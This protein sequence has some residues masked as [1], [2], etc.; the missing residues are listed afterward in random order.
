[1]DA[2]TVGLD[3]AK[4]VFHVHVVDGSGKVLHSKKL[5]RSH[6]EPF[7]ARLRRAVVGIEACGTA[8]HWARTLTALGHEVRLIPAAY[9]KPFVRRNKNDAR[10]AEGSVRRSVGRT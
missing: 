1:M 6:V 8:H 4:S 5:R 9:V 10:D 3:L 2:I 7:F